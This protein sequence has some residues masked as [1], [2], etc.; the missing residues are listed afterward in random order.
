VIVGNRSPI[1][2]SAK[3][4]IKLN[5][6]CG[7]MLTIEVLL[8]PKLHMS[9]LLVSELEAIEAMTFFGGH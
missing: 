4:T 7:R 3:R 6:P 8:V 1:L 9:L 5:L 2:A